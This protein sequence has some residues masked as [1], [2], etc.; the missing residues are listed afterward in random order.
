MAEWGRDRGGRQ[1]ERDLDDDEQQS[2]HTLSGI[3]PDPVMALQ[4]T[5]RYIQRRRDRRSAEAGDP[6]VTGNAPEA[7]QRADQSSGAPLPS[8]LQR[9]FEQSLGTRLGGVRVHTGSESVAAAESVSA[10][11]YTV[12]SNIHFASGAYDPA[13]R[14][15]QELLAHEVAHTVQ[16]SGG[17]SGP[18]CKLEVSEP[19]DPAEHEAD[20]AGRAMVTGSPARVSGRPATVSRQGDDEKLKAQAD[21]LATQLQTVIDGAVWKEIRKRVYPKESAAGKAE[22]KERKKDKNKPDLSGLG[23]ISAVEHFV[24]KVKALQSSWSKQSPQDRATALGAA[25]SDEMTAADVPKFLGVNQVKIEWKAFF[26]ASDW[27]FNINKDLLAGD[28]LSDADAGDLC[29]TALHEARHAEQHFL[30]ARFSAGPPLNKK[31]PEIAA[32]EGIPPEVAKVAKP[33]DAAADPTAAAL[34]KEMYQAMVTDQA[35]NQKISDDDYTKEMKTARDQAI[36]SLAALKGSP[37]AATIADAT[38]KM[39]VLKDAI[40][41][42]E[43]RYTLYRKIPYEADAHAVGDSAE[44]A[45]GGWK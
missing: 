27:S 33:L 30:A 16:Q 15:G 13:S 3:H 39:N 9:R 26:R 29:N 12:G 41:E 6:E 24:G 25:I 32:E 38:A 19:G 28:T 10:R 37:S 43:R 2:G 21:A 17:A 5:R 11:A 23:K 44:L 36:N 8:A 40:A 34:G 35:A 4:T 20:A 42:V 7:L 14:S 45:F 31:A 18:Q 22:A 1:D